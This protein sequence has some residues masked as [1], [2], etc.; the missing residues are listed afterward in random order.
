MSTGL[1]IVLAVIGTGVALAALIAAQGSAQ[2]RENSEMRHELGNV[3][4][5]LARLEGVID[6]IRTGMQL[7]R[8]EEPD[9]RQS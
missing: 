3:R 9:S 8:P 2:R 7:P 1:E 5:R 6:I 4:E